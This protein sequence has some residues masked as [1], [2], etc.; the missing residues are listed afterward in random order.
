MPQVVQSDGVQPRPFEGLTPLVANGVLVRG[1]GLATREQPFARVDELLTPLEDR[2][3]LVRHRDRALRPVPRQPDLD[4]LATRPLHLPA[5][6][7]FR[8]A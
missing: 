3:Q 5:D 7:S 2:G 1:F 4:V 6:V 8:C